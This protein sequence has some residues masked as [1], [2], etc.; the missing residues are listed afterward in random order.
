VAIRSLTRRGRVAVAAAAGLTLVLAGCGDD[1]GGDAG[2][3]GGGGGTAASTEPLP[4][5]E[6]DD[7]LAALVPADVAEDGVLTVGSDTTY[8]PNEFVAED[9]ETIVGFDVDLF[10]LVAQKLGLE[11]QF[12]TAPF[13][14]IIAGVGSG[15][16]EVG[17]SS[18]TINPDR[19]QQVNMIS[20]YSAGT[21]WA[22]KAGNPEGVDPDNACGLTVAVQKATVQV[23]DITARSEACEAA[24]EE[25]ITIN[26]YDGQ[27]QATA[28]IV[29]GAAVAGLAD[30]PIMAY[31]VQQ[32]NGQL[33]LL[34]D[35]YDSAPYGY[36]VPQDQAEFAQALADAVR[37]L[38][39]DGT[40]TQV[41]ERWGVEDGA[42]DDPTVNPTAG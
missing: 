23:E 5:V 22:T 35:I 40:Y 3:G 37:A 19:L 34:G 8:A 30:S 15:R 17:V 36:V 6:A 24:G 38:I 4:S 13:D 18:F 7:A 42:I 21:Q 32:T 31:A 26:Q 25:P 2:S 14:S 11:A 28:A 9:G 39:E 12:Q 20:Y 33:E 27:D 41:L 1:S 10:T 16:Y 29:S